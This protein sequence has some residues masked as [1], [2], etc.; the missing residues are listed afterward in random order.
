MGSSLAYEIHLRRSHGA[1]M[2]GELCIV[3][4]GR[5]QLNLEGFEQTIDN[6]STVVALL[7]CC[8]VQNQIV[9]CNNI[10]IIYHDL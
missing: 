2:V 10:E 4:K 6:M 1:E 8:P 9:E 3:A 7:Y 5:V